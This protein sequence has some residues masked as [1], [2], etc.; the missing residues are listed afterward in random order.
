[1]LAAL[2]VLSMAAGPSGSPAACAAIEAD[3]ARLACYDAIYRDVTAATRTPGDDAVPRSAEPGTGAAST[4]A[5]ATA[6]ST[7]AVAARS[8]PDPAVDFGLTEQQKAVKQPDAKRRPQEIQGVVREVKK[9]AVDRWAFFL[10]NGQLWQQAESTSRQ[11]FKTGDSIQIREAAMS[12][13][14]A[15]GPNSGG[16]V[17]VRRAR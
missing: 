10:E 5:V 3:A 16:S 14:L 6:A 15:T 2:V 4:A 13:Y 1:M 17:R 7:G 12:S 11:P 9:I 8:A